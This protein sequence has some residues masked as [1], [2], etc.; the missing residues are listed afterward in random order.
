L[1]HG[2]VEVTCI[3]LTLVHRWLESHE[4]SIM[5]VTIFVL[6]LWWIFCLWDDLWD[7]NKFLSLMYEYMYM[8]PRSCVLVLIKLVCQGLWGGYVHKLE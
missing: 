8:L 5:I 7:A 4:L 2:I 6:S 1:D 3:K